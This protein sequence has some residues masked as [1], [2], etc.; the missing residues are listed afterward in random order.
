MTEKSVSGPVV[1]AELLSNWQLQDSKIVLLEISRKDEKTDVTLRCIPQFRNKRQYDFVEIKFMDVEV[2]DF[3][4]A[5]D[6]REFYFVNS[7]IGGFFNDR[8]YLS[9]DPYDHTANQPDERDSGVIVG[10]QVTARFVTED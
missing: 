1:F 10:R 7:Y 9:V 5:K 4:W 3:F 2:F 6:T 8:A